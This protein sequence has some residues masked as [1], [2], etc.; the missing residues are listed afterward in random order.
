MNSGR[1]PAYISSSRCAS[2]TSETT[3]DF[4]LLIDPKTQPGAQAYVA[5]PCLKDFV[6]SREQ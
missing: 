1:R 3:E 5:G 4:E 6:D 2:L